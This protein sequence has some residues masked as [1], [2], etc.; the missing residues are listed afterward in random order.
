MLKSIIRGALFSVAISIL[1]VIFI[2]VEML[3]VPSQI[4]VGILAGLLGA[5]IEGTINNRKY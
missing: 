2:E 4:A 3:G 5:A 1:A